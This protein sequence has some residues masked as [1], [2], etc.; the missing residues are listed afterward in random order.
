[1][2]IVVGKGINQF[3]MREKKEEKAAEKEGIQSHTAQQITF[4]DFDS[5][6]G[7]CYSPFPAGF[8]WSTVSLASLLPTL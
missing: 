2:Y 5:S 6:P 7:L 3:Q 4:K 8:P 1:M